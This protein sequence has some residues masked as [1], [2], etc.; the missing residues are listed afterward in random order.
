MFRDGSI[1]NVVVMIGLALFK[2][3]VAELTSFTTHVQS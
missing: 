2:W 3:G 1:A